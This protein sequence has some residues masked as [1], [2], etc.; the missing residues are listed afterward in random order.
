MIRLTS[1]VIISREKEN[2]PFH[3]MSFCYL[4]NWP[5]GHLGH[6]GHDIL[7]MDI[8]LICQFVTTHVIL[9]SQ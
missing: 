1:T 9:L 3:D 4:N 7:S 6:L 5:L 2:M 8:L